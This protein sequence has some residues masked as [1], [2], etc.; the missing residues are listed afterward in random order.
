MG[1]AQH[2]GEQTFAR[3][4]GTDFQETPGPGTLK[5]QF[6]GKE[7]THEMENQQLHNL[8][9]YFFSEL[10]DFEW[11]FFCFLRRKIKCFLLLWE[12]SG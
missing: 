10:D 6:V 4:R 9:F 11:I 8:F 5:T 7:G 12:F 3:S 1:L 2:F